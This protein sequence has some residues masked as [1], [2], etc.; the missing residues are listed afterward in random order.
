MNKNKIRCKNAL[1]NEIQ[2]SKMDSIYEIKSLSINIS[3]E[4]KFFEDMIM[5]FNQSEINNNKINKYSKYHA[6][7]KG[8]EENQLQNYSIKIDQADT[9]IL[10]LFDQSQKKF[11]ATKAKDI[12]IDYCSTNQR[13]ASFMEFSQHLKLE[14]I[15]QIGKDIYLN[16]NNKKKIEKN[17]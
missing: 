3:D 15:L 4:D 11:V 5:L 1:Q 8:F 6:L 10:E 9:D 16:K 12:N 13:I 14:Y 7:L 17:F 2:E